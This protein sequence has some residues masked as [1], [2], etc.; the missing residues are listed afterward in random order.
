MIRVAVLAG[1]V[2]ASISA[3]AHAHTDL[4]PAEVRA[5]LDAGA[6]IVVLDVREVS[7]FCDSTYTPP[8]HIPGAIN[9]PWNSGYLQDHYDELSQAD[10]TIVVCRSGNRSNTAANFLE[11]VGFIHVFDMLGGMNAW[12][13]ETASCGVA[14]IPGSGGIT[15][16]G[17][18]LGPATPN[19]FNFKTEI[20]YVIP[21][22][23]DPARATISVY[24]S[25]GRLVFRV[26]DTD[27]GPGSHRV[28][29]DGNDS[30]G[31]PV[32][33][34]LYFYQLALNGQT[35]TR[36]LALLR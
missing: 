26:V 24:D 27:R 33:S 29:W 19:P 35:V 21:A 16:S 32:A 4:T 5:L 3:S 8:G 1:L 7:E 6:N 10:S 23:L 12:L 18:A 14:S 9:M 30:V 22:G 11:D 28:V 36:R 20:P 25:G 31:R 34:G 13:W 17:F 2:L 15:L